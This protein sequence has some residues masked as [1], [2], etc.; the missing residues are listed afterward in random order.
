METLNEFV[1]RLTN[2]VG[3]YSHPCKYCVSL[4]KAKSSVRRQMSVF[5]WVEV[6]KQKRAFRISTYKDLAEK[7]GVMDLVDGERANMHWERTGVFFIVKH[8]STGADY[9][10]AM[11]ALSAVMRFK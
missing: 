2:A 7:A 11:R 6:L 9:K 8:S 3:C 1:K 10:K 4:Q 5:G